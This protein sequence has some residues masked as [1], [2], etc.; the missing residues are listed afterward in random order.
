M[1]RSGLLILA[2]DD[3]PSPHVLRGAASD[4]LSFD[5]DLTPM[6]PDKLQIPDGLGIRPARP[7]DQPFLEAL[8]RS[9]RGDLRLIDAED[10]FIEAL[11]AQQ[12]QAQTAGYGAMFPNAMYFVVE[13][14]G[15]AIGRAVVDFG[16]NEVRLVDVAF[17]P[18][19]RG[20][21]H[22]EAVIRGLQQA[23]A[24]A[25]APLA[26][27]AMKNNPAAHRLYLRLG[28]RVEESAEAHDRMVWYPAAADGGGQV[29]TTNW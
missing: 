23:A 11:T 6:Q 26:L 4:F 27:T 1:S 25:G 22:G 10:G 3:Y 17:I 21:G 2:D 7:S 9:T 8:Y 28:F 20:K 5:N 14:H 15:Q 18:E 16:H 29:L 12:H 19:A 24:Q 13:Q